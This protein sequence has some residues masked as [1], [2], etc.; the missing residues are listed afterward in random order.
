MFYL[1][2]NCPFPFYFYNTHLHFTVKRMA[3]YYTLLKILYLEFYVV[4]NNKI[5][6]KHHLSN[7][8]FVRIYHIYVELAP[9]ELWYMRNSIIHQKYIGI[10]YFWNIYKQW[11]VN[12]ELH[13]RGLCV[14]VC[15]NWIILYLIALCPCFIIY[16]IRREILYSA[17]HRS[18]E[19]L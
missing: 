7:L 8:W 19:I 4:I 12:L 5:N 17:D 11:N 14:Y 16:C 9:S 18:V 6:Y 2:P 10:I 3:L 15:T 13:D 1:K